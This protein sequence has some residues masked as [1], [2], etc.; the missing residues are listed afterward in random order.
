M[1]FVEIERCGVCDPQSPDPDRS[2]YASD[3]WDDEWGPEDFFVPV[4]SACDACIS[5]GKAIRGN[6]ELQNSGGFAPVYSAYCDRQERCEHCGVAFIFSAKEQKYWYENLA[7]YTRSEPAGCI[8]CRRRR[9][10]RHDLNSRIAK[11]LEVL[12]EKSWLSLRDL[13]A[14]YLEFGARRKAIEFLRRAKNLCTDEEALAEIWSRISEAE[15]SSLPVWPNGQFARLKQLNS[16][17]KPERFKEILK[18]ARPILAPEAMEISQELY[19]RWVRARY[20]KHP[21]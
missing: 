19:Q 4:T 6:P 9:R 8:D 1:G 7:F 10:Y 11:T 18:Q 2:L 12:D 5:K 15:K 16:D 13:G 20:R 3:L 17:T 21:E 14:L